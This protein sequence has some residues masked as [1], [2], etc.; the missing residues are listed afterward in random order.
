VPR[1]IAESVWYRLRAARESRAKALRSKRAKT[2]LM[3]A[4]EKRMRKLVM[5]IMMMTLMPPSRSQLNKFVRM[6]SILAPTVSTSVRVCGIR[7][8]AK[9]K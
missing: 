6:S 1:S 7:L 3:T 2:V 8:T 5:T 9:T 4:D